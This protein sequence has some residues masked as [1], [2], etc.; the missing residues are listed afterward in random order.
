MDADLAG[1]DGL[2][3]VVA[4]DQTRELVVQIRASSLRP[5]EENRTLNFGVELGAQIAQPSDPHGDL[6]E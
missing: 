4:L 5:G 3:L 6:G 2:G 1:G